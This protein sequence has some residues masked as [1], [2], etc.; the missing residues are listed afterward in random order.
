MTWKANLQATK[1]LKEFIRHPF[2]WP[3]G[4]ERVAVCHDGG[5]LCHACCKREFKGIL[6]STLF[7]F[8][9]GWDITGI[10]VLTG[11]KEED[12]NFY[13]DHCSKSFYSED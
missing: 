2:A 10:Q 5:L 8:R 13:C 9:D 12:E 4:Y 6:H 1:S 7:E 3:G 11:C